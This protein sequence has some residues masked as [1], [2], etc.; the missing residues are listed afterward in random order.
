[1]PRYVHGY[2]YVSFFVFVA[3]SKWHFIYFLWFTAYNK[4]LE[5]AITVLDK[6]AMTIDVNDRKLL[7]V[8]LSITANTRISS[9]WD[10][11]AFLV[12]IIGW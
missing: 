3:G 6:I 10:I 5:D 9:K 1:M 11:D 4:A 2:E 12:D 8:D 7:D